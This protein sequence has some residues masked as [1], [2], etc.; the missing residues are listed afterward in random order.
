M[1]PTSPLILALAATA[2][3][4]LAV[5]T[6]AAPLLVYS[7]SLATL[8]LAHVAVEMRY[9]EGR[10][11][12]RLSRTLIGGLF[13]LLGAVVLL[14]LLRTVGMLGADAVPVELGIVAGLT[15]LVT[16]DVG[17]RTGLGAVAGLLALG[18]TVG[19]V[20]APIPTILLL[21]VLH[22]WTP[23]GFVAEATRGPTRRRWLGWGV[24]A[25]V[26]L[27]GLLASGVLHDATA[28]LGL[29][30]ATVFG[31]GPLSR[32]LGAYLPRDWHAETWAVPVFSAIAFAQ[33]MHYA[34]V[35]GVLPRFA[36]QAPSGPLGRPSWSTYLGLV[37]LG[38]AVLLAGYAGDFGLARQTYGI[39]A[40]VHAWVELPLLLLALR[41]ATS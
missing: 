30:D 15:G 32:Q 21:G 14:R 1:P 12:P 9:V 5:A 7:V 36:P 20:F 6:A 37:A 25:F 41:P 33:C 4:G 27:P 11:G 17:L 31:T 2:L 3:V 26:V 16:L 28:S 10:F 40:A 22:N 24:V 35:L 38:T 29:Q 18:V 34:A 23:L 39:V 13:V 19:A 8:G